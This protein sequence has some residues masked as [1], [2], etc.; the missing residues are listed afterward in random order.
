MES[1][2]HKE[3][4]NWPERGI[5]AI[6]IFARVGQQMEQDRIQAAADVCGTSVVACQ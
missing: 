5:G 4:Q 3:P 6:E 1:A 2:K